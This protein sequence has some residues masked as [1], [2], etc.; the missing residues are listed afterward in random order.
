MRIRIVYPARSPHLI[1]TARLLA[2]CV[3]LYRLTGLQRVGLQTSGG[4]W[5]YTISDMSKTVSA[6]VPA[7]NEALRLPAILSLLC[8]YPGF[9][10]V[11]VV[12]DGS[13]DTTAAVVRGF[14]VKCLY[15]TEKQGKG[16]AMEHGVRAARGEIL[17]FCDADTR[18]LTHAM[19]TTLL[20]PVLQQQAS[21]SVAVRGR[22]ISLIMKLLAWL[23]PMS[24]LIA[25]ER[26]VTKKLWD[27]LPENY[28]QGY[29]VETGL[30]YLADR[31]TPG[32]VY[33]VFPGLTHVPKELKYGMLTGYTARLKEVLDVLSAH[34]R[35]FINRDPH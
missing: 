34:A 31:H 5:Y 14:P 33:H 12:S 9:L 22:N 35:W 2:L 30:N 29:Q 10:E 23:F 17:F 26:A 25:G 19:I 6:I 13:T 20:Q 16:L 11:I 15:Q 32:L 28:K 18:G 3:R 1:L 4:F 21:M 8:S 24:S 27:E 7:Y